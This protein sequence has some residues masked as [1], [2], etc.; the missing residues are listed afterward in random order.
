MFLHPTL[1]GITILLV[2]VDDIII[3]R[4]DPDIILVLQNSLHASFHMK[5]LEP[6]TSFLSLEVHSLDREIFINQYKYT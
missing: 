2:Y 3:T 1:H 4:T 5:D 6:P